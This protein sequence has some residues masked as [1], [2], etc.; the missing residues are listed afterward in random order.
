MSAVAMASV[1]ALVDRGELA[2]GKTS[3]GRGARQRIV[4][5]PHVNRYVLL[6]ALA[7]SCDRGTYRTDVLL[8][9]LCK[10]TGLTY[11]TAGRTLRSLVADGY[12]KV[13]HRRNLSSIYELQVHLRVAMV[14]TP[15]GHGGRANT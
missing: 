2:G 14:A 11:R 9:D 12:V 15:F 8:G 10:R 5:V 4:I 3:E 7:W 1:R 6:H 13:T